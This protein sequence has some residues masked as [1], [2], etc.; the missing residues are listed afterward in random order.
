MFR[1]GCLNHKTD[2]LFFIFYLV[3]ALFLSFLV[4]AGVVCLRLRR[5][6]G[7]VDIGIFKVI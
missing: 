2:D 5:K 6:F 3:S 1:S 7:L 4:R